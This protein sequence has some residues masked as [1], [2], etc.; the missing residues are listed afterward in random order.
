MTT[1]GS[2]TLPPHHSHFEHHVRTKGWGIEPGWKLVSKNIEEKRSFTMQPTLNHEMILSRN[3]SKKVDSFGSISRRGGSITGLRERNAN[4]GV[5]DRDRFTHFENGIG[6]MKAPPPP[7]PPKST[8]VSSSLLSSSSS[9]ASAAAV[10]TWRIGAS[11]EDI[12]PIHH[13]PASSSSSSYS[14]SLGSAS[15]P[16]ATSNVHWFSSV[17]RAAGGRHYTSLN[18]NPRP[19]ILPAMPTTT[20]ATAAT[21]TTGRAQSPPVDPRRYS[22]PPSSVASG[23]SAASS[24]GSG[25]WP[26]V[27]MMLMSPVAPVGVLKKPGSLNRSGP[28]HMKKVAFLENAEFSRGIP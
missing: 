9:S 19:S 17:G 6:R 10:P 26:E 18:S 24:T 7:P 15:A 27:S 21:S 12:C 5:S 25:P 20:T 1:F 16:S 22:P 11:K 13:V 28:K 4:S 2:A 3:L 23:A 14:S 8:V